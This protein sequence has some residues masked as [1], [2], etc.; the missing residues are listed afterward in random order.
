MVTVRYGAIEIVVSVYTPVAPSSVPT[1]TTLVST[2]AYPTS[3]VTTTWR[4]HVPSGTPRVVVH[5][6]E[7]DGVAFAGYMSVIVAVSVT[8]PVFVTRIVYVTGSPDSTAAL[9]ARLVTVSAG[10]TAAS[11]VSVYT[12]LTPS[13]VVTSPS[14]TSVPL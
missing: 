13:S 9:S 1:R 2:P 12:A 4:L 5:V 14:F 10:V 11:E 7:P 8:F 3:G 6:S